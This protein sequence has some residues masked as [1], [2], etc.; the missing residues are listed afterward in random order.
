MPKMNRLAVLAAACGLVFLAITVP[1]AFASNKK[2]DKFLDQGRAAET[3]REYDKALDFY[4]KAVAADPRDT[5][6]ILALRR[7]RFAAGQS[8]VDAGQKLRREGNLEGALAEFQR[9]FAIDPASTIAEQE[10]RR[11]NTMIEREKAKKEDPNAA[12]ATPPNEAGLT[13]A[14]MARKDAEQRASRILPMPELKPISQE[15]LGLK[16]SNQGTKVLYETL[17]KVAGINVLFDSEFQDQQKKFSV[18]L[19]NTTLDE[20]LD[21]LALLT[22]TFV[23]PLSANTI[24]V[25]QDNVTKRRDYEEQVTR[26]FYLQNLTSPQ[27]LQEVMTGMRTVT[28]V[29]K[30]FPVNSQSAIVVRGTSD[31]VALAEKVLLDLDKAKP[32]VVVDVIVMEANKDRTRDIGM[33]LVSG[34]KNGF[35]SS[36]TPTPGGSSSGSV[37]LKGLSSLGLG[38][39]SATVPGAFVEA[40]AKDS[41]SKVITTPQ[42]RATDGQKATLRLGDRY[43]YATGSFQSGAGA[44]GVSPLVSTQFQFAE[45]GVNLDLTPRIHSN[46]EV[47]MQ[48]EFEISNIRDKVDV[49]GLSQ[50]VIGQRKVSHII[51]VREGEVTLIGGLMQ[52]TQ[53]KVRSGLPG[54][55]NLPFFGRFFSTDS[56]ENINSDLL[57]ALVPHIVRGPEVTAENVRAIATGSETIYKLNYS[58]RKDAKKAAPVASPKPGAGP[59]GLPMASP[60]K[61]TVPT[62]VVPGGETPRSQPE[63]QPV[64]AVQANPAV[65]P[66]NPGLGRPTGGPGTP[67]M[68]L[69]PSASQV[70]PA[71]TFTVTLQVDNVTDLFTAPMRVTYDNKVLKLV[72]VTKGDF[73]GGDGQQVTFSESKVEAQGMAIVN[74]NRLPGA[75]GISGSGTLVNLKF[76][77][78]AAGT[79]Q[80]TLAD[81]TLR[82]ARLQSIPVTAPVTSITVK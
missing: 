53:T 61:V 44:V 73:M 63:S 30:V 45:V 9:A 17:G 65:S 39:W 72:E 75:G 31:Q 74:M 67:T 33:S 59:S 38:D 12:A 50:P 18:D 68:M 66:D 62:P 32:E 58:P 16:M 2:G 71:E 27:E 81:L 22:K 46:D 80:I 56:I 20:A 29:R 10:M 34:G 64:P 43:P 21:Y 25:T 52:A 11:T 15:L 49:G 60:S 35:S 23:K 5:G 82:D 19:S 77:A 70:S 7:V 79:S 40:L 28:D 13:P 51:R 78:V 3:A 47:S 57:V 4:E 6:Y 36:I 54:L 41:S 24:F 14:E 55:M 69:R 8:H 26:I 37:S 42:V 1:L 76:T 48:V